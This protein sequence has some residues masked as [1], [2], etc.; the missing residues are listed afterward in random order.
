MASETPTQGTMSTSS[1]N[2]NNGPSIARQGS[3][4][5]GN[6]GN[7]R[8]QPRTIATNAVSY[9]GECEEIGHTL[10]LRSERFDK[11]LHFQSFLDKI[12]N[13]VVPNLDNGGDIQSLYTDLEDPI[14]TF[15]INNKPIKPD[16]SNEEVDEVDMEIYREEVKQ[17]VRRK[18]MLR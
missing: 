17:F 4:A 7:R 10:A 18:A 5:R 15:L 11:K 6:Q 14:Q 13:Y 16:V 1:E 12:S 9:H 8:Q 3:S 2:A